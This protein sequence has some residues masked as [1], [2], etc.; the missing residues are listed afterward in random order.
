L[1]HAYRPPRSGSCYYYGSTALC[2]ALAAFSVSLSYTRLVGL[3]G[4][5][6]NTSQGLYLHTEQHKPRINARN[7]D[8]HVLSGIRTHDPSVQASEDSSCLRP[9]GRCVPFVGYPVVCI[10]E[11][12]SSNLIPECDFPEWDVRNFPSVFLNPSR[13]ITGPAPVC[14]R[15]PPFSYF[16]PKTSPWTYGVDRRYEITCLCGDEDLWGSGDKSPR[17][18]NLPLYETS[19]HLRPRIW[20]DPGYRLDVRLGRLQNR[21]GRGRTTN[22]L[23]L[24]WIPTGCEAG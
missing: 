6:K 21:P 13:K 3:L 23:V 18:L 22:W 16:P 7:T 5:G 11:V 4:R 14:S 17:I 2:W 19:G 24:L 20:T 8:T 1:K 12:T 15:C 10:Q 9:R